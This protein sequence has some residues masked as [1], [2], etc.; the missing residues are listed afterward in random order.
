LSS[1]ISALAVGSSCWEIRGWPRALA[2]NRGP[3]EHVQAALQLLGI[4]RLALADVL[5]NM[6]HARV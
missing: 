2:S 3:R 1:I 4:K 5:R 6:R